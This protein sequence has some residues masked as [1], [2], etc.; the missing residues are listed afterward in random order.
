MGTTSKCRVG[1]VTLKISHWS[2]PTHQLHVY[3][4]HI[5]C[6]IYSVFL[7]HKFYT[8][9]YLLQAKHISITTFESW[10]NWCN[11]PLFSHLFSTL[12][13]YFKFR[14]Y[15]NVFLQLLLDSYIIYKILQNNILILVTNLFLLN[16]ISYWHEIFLTFWYAFSHSMQISSLLFNQNFTV[17]FKQTFI[18]DQI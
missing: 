14:N 10:L 12:H 2:S 15:K 7:L 3:R 13:L 6:C 18:K 8:L 5:L 16:N 17:L 9:N 11:F 1:K 4:K